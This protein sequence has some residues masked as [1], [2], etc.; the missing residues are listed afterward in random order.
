MSTGTTTGGLPNQFPAPGSNYLVRAA[1]HS[2]T[3]SLW[4]VVVWKDNIPLAYNNGNNG[5]WNNTDANWVGGDP[6]GTIHLF[7]AQAFAADGQSDPIYLITKSG[8]SQITF[9]DLT[10]IASYNPQQTNQPWFPNTGLWQLN[11]SNWNSVVKSLTNNS[12]GGKIIQ[13]TGDIYSF[14]LLKS[15]GAQGW[16][17]DFDNVHNL[18]IQGV[19]GQTALVWAI[20]EWNTGLALDPGPNP[21]NPSIYRSRFYYPT[22]GD[23]YHPFATKDHDRDPTSCNYYDNEQPHFFINIKSNCANITI[24]GIRFSTDY[25][26]RV[27]LDGS[28]IKLAGDHQ[29]ITHC[30]FEKSPGFAV[31]SSA[32]S[33][34]FVDSCQFQNTY[35]DG[36][37]IES[38]N[39]NVYLV[40]NYFSN[41]RD[42]SISIAGGTRDVRV[43]SN[44]IVGTKSRG[45]FVWPGSTLI[46]ISNNYID[47]TY[48][49]GI[50]VGG[51]NMG[52]NSSDGNFPWSNCIKISG[53]F[54]RRIGNQPNH[55]FGETAAG[56]YGYR[57][58]RIHNLYI[59]AK[60]AEG[61]LIPGLP[62]GIDYR[63]YAVYNDPSS[64]HWGWVAKISCI[65]NAVTNQQSPYLFG[66]D[67]NNCFNSDGNGGGGRD[68]GDRPENT[69][70]PQPWVDPNG[71]SLLA[72][73]VISY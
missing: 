43:W 60:P 38:C 34:V 62:A 27:G 54:L 47:G 10:S 25:T 22:A 8:G 65:N 42:D 40:G 58:D 50:H 64:A 32:Q 23:T 37:H 72:L 3:G 30:V 41:T 57:L 39:N 9:S 5:W 15:D 12:A 70:F 67:H 59:D 4:N 33:Y 2:D 28:H 19:E 13:F 49:W 55:T 63:D 71:Q 61:M 29:Q 6:A 45:I 73:P 53:N 69:T 14:A 46:D 52:G 68:S 51:D 20:R 16:M 35:A 56:N 36:L 24:S 7:K 21:S 18:T 1:G 17:D 26:N 66:V 44:T 11:T 31:N 48:S